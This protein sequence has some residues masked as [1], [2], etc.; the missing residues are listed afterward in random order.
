MNLNF[1]SE[2][3]YGSA[4]QWVYSN[5][6][7]RNFRSSASNQSGKSKDF[8]FVKCK[9]DICHFVCCQMLNFQHLFLRI[10]FIWWVLLRYFTTCHKTDHVIHIHFP[11][12]N[13]TESFSV[14]HDRNPVPDPLEFFHTVGNINDRTTL[15]GDFLYSL[16][17]AVN[18]RVC[19][20][21]S[22]L[23][24]NDD[25]CSKCKCLG[26]FYHLL[27]RNAQIRYLSPGI[28]IK[29]QPVYDLCSLFV[30]FL[31]IQ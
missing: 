19:K 11:D 21:G 17:K 14:T 8:S 20:C 16:K 29:V 13:G 5:D 30:Q 25:F 15:T 1:F 22:R 27:L 18:L 23:I 26:Y 2:N 6:S 28:N 4:F 31:F 10:C 12:F 3:G 9:A 7:T 24:H